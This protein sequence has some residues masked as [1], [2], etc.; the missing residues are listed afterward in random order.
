MAI[1]AAECLAAQIGW[2]AQDAVESTPFDDF[3]ELQKPMEETFVISYG[4]RRGH[5]LALRMPLS[6]PI[7]AVVF[8]SDELGEILRCFGQIKLGNR[9]GGNLFD[10]PGVRALGEIQIFLFF[11]V[12]F[13]GC[14]FR[15]ELKSLS[16]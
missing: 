7:K 3:R 8:I 13:F 12:D 16:I 11:G 15:A 2:V 5:R 14:V 9:D 1:C 10:Q 4:R 6:G